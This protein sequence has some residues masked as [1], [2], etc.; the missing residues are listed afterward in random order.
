LRRQKCQHAPP[1]PGGARQFFALATPGYAPISWSITSRPKFAAILRV[2]DLAKPL[3]CSRRGGDG[4]L[5]E[6]F[7]WLEIGVNFIK[8]LAGVAELR[9][10]S[11]GRAGS[12]P[13]GL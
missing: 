9:S 1:L 4:G 6:M 7:N 13:S 10:Q 12:Q 5:R 11:K 8:T 3:E 2:G